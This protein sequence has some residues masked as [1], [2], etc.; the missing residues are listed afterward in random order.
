MNLQARALL[1]FALAIAIMIGINNKVITQKFGYA[2]IAVVRSQHTNIMILVIVRL[3]VLMKI[4]LQHQ[5][6][7]S[8]LFAIKTFAHAK[9][10]KFI[11]RAPAQLKDKNESGLSIRVL[12]NIAE[13]F[14]H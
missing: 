1:G 3:P 12:A 11:A 9:L 10:L 8:V 7:K 14:S 13:K 5:R 4:C 2:L 6:I